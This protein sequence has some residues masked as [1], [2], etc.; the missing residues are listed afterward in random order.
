[1]GYRP[2]HR[3]QESMTP[4]HFQEGLQLEPGSFHFQER[5]LLEPPGL[6]RALPQWRLLAGQQPRPP[7]GQAAA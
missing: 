4:C 1:M 3:F 2:Q 7:V 5:L 6:A